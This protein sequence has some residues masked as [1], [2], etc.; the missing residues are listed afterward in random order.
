[1]TLPLIL[2][3]ISVISFL[4]VGT[5]YYV[6]RFGRSDAALA[7]Y[8]T[9]VIAASILASKAIA[10]DLGFITLYA[11]G[12]VLIFSVTFLLTDIVNERFG[13]RETQRMIWF[14]FLAQIAFAVFTYFVIAAVP[15]P[16]FPHQEA[17]ELVL[18]NVPRIVI[19]GLVAFLVSELLDAHIFQWFRR[20]TA[21]RHLWMRNAFSTLPAM[22]VD[23]MIFVTIAFYGVVPILPLMVGLTAM[24]WLVGVIDIPFMYAARLVM[25]KY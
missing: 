20:L 24:K 4:A 17:F 21:D 11:P 14:A 16:F 3:W 22:A 8:V 23:S 25:G 10:F 7:L 6:R 5:A 9:L 12:A 18:S 13:K 15:A 2:F 19:A 1:M